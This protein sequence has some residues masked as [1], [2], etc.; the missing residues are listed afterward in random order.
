[1]PT[2]S[3][4]AYASVL[5]SLGLTDRLRDLADENYDTVGRTPEEERLPKRIRLKKS[6][7]LSFKKLSFKRTKNA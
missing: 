3:I 4:G 2:V 6:K 5:S 1:M 7:T